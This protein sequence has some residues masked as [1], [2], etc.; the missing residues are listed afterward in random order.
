MPPSW[1]WIWEGGSSPDVWCV[2]IPWLAPRRSLSV[3]LSCQ[4]LPSVPPVSRWLSS[5]APASRTVQHPERAAFLPQISLPNTEVVSGWPLQIQRRTVISTHGLPHPFPT[6]LGAAG[7]H[8][9]VCFSLKKMIKYFSKNGP[10]APPWFQIYNKHTLRKR[11]EPQLGTH[12]SSSSKRALPPEKWGAGPSH[13][14]AGM[15]A[16]S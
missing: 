6:S 12:L 3:S 5:V 10:N 15:Q 13:S 2:L 9:S 1:A 8:H 14:V 4:A 7:L 11:N 16:D